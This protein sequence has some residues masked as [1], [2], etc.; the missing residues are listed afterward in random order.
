MTL[1]EAGCCGRAERLE[2]PLDNSPAPRA[3]LWDWDRVEASGC[4]SS[5]VENE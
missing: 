2:P 4:S 5:P 3:A 1:W